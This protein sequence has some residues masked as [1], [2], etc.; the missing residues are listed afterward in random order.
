MYGAV[1]KKYKIEIRTALELFQ[2]KQVFEKMISQ[3][4]YL[5]QIGLEEIL[6]YV[7]EIINE[8]HDKLILYH[9]TTDQFETIDLT[10]SY[11]KRDFGRGFYTT[12]LEDQAKEWVYRLSIRRGKKIYYINQYEFQGDKSLRIKKFEN[13][14]DEWLDFIKKNRYNGGVAH[15]FDVVMGP[16]ADDNTMETV[17]LYMSGIYNKKEALER[18]KYYKVN[19]QISFHTERSLRYIKLLGRKKYDGANIYI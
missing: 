8:E 12:L 1:Q 19:N 4:E 9:G 16:V 10:K 18:L 13:F 7:E 2:K 17:Q 15:N 5:H 14:S 11:N 3:H 6:E